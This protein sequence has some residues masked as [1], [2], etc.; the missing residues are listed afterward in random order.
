MKDLI[1]QYRIM[2]AVTSAVILLPMIVGLVL[3][4]RIPAQVPVHFGIYGEP[5]GYGPK[6]IAVILLPMFLMIMQAVILW[7]F[8]MEQNKENR[9]YMGYVLLIFPLLSVYLNSLIY[10]S[11]L[12]VK[13]NVNRI[14]SVIAGCVFIGLGAVLPKLKKNH[15]VG[16][17]LP[18]TLRSEENWKKTHAFGGKV[19]MICGICILINSVL[20]IG[21][22]ASFFYSV[23]GALMAL[24][25][26]TGYYSWSY[27]KKERS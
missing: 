23:S 19:T 2:L 10:G 25:I 9:K 21:G 6:W 1:R 13:M 8:A 3:W 16:I 4:N 17:R 7:A 22:D 18:W 14:G 5:D 15:T 24:L 27:S 20:Q 11:L 26:S 12:G